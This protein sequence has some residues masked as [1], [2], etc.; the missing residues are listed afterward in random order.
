MSTYVDAAEAARLLGVTRPTLYAYVSRGKL[1]RRTAVDGRTSLF[2]L[3]EI[4]ALQERARSRPRP[5]PSIDVRIT[6]AITVL[7]EDGLLYRGHPVADLARTSS[8]E[9]VAELL[10]SGELPDG[11]VRWPAPSAD[12]VA[13]CRRLVEPAFDPLQV[14]AAATLA[15]GV[16]HTRA[17]A[18][19]AA[20]LLVQ[21]SPVLLGPSDDISM[22]GPVA[23]RLAAAW[24]PEP[25]DE[26][27]AAV[28]RALVVLADHELAT[29][30]L[31][32]RVAGSVRADPWSAF[33]A[34]M[35]VLRAPLHG[36]AAA[37]AHRLFV[38]A[39]EL[40][41]ERAVAE[42]LAATRRLAGYGH[43]V[44]RGEDPRFGVV[45]DAVRTL[46]DPR[47]R[48][49]LVDEL[50]LVTGERVT[51]RPNVDLA[52]A[53]LTYVGGLDPHVPMFAVARLAGWAAHLEEELQEQ[54]LRFRGL[55]RPPE[56]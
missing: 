42:A 51:V 31:A 41:A 47:G 52:L 19:D 38:Q 21:L 23:P 1:S 44:Y 35:H 9:Q 3:D 55:A 30:T 40:G 32:V 12:D 11:E 29:S 24:H 5:R 54:P 36:S 2:A 22:A 49:T 34:G 17:S 43:T 20:R 46:P 16:R 18:R 4:E 14:L 27:V 8:F 39:E 45:L 15:L 26:L 25:L 50:L 28:D 53:A 13:A 7:D 33:A 56:P 37:M 48:M 10:W 6:S